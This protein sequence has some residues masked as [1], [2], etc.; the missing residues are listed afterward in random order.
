MIG[1]ELEPALLAMRTKDTDIFVLWS[2]KDKE[3]ELLGPSLFTV[4]S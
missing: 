4:W 3:Q 2:S 1:P